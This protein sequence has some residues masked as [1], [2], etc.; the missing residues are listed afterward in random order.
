MT[1]DT[2][3]IPD[4][5]TPAPQPARPSPSTRPGAA[6]QPAGQEDPPV[7]TTK[8]PEGTAAGQQVGAGYRMFEL[9]GSGGMGAVYRGETK[10]GDPVA[11]KLLRPELASDTDMVRR[12]LQ[13]RAILTGLSH[14]NIVKIR[15]LVAEGGTIAIVMDLVQGPDLRRELTARKTLPPAQAAALMA[16]VLRG[17]AAVHAAGVVHRDIKPENVLLDQSAGAG[18]SVPKLTDFG[19]ARIA[20]TSDTLRQTTLIGTPLYMAP[21]LVDEKQPTVASDL[22]AAGI[23]LYEL[24]AG[25]TPFG[26]GT[27]MATLNKHVHES[28]GRPPG[29]PQALWDILTPMLAKDPAARPASAGVVAHALD[30]AAEKLAGLPALTPL[31]VPPPADPDGATARAPVVPTVPD[32]PVADVPARFTRRTL[33]IAGVLAVLLLA[34]GGTAAALYMKNSATGTPVAGPTTPVTTSSSAPTSSTTST[35]TT[36]TTS[37]TSSTS[38]T[39]AT[40]ST[41]SLTAGAAMPDLK[42]MKV[43]LALSTIART[44]VSYEIKEVPNT[45]VPDGTVLDQSPAAGQPL[46]PPI[47]ITVARTPTLVYLAD[48]KY[49]SER[50]VNSDS[51]VSVNGNTYIHGL[52]LGSVACGGGTASVEYDLSRRYTKL[53][54]VIGQTDRSASGVTTRTEISLDGKPVFSKQFG[55]GQPQQLDLD[56]TGALRL[57]IV[58]TNVGASN[59]CAR[60]SVAV[61]F[62]DPQLNGLPQPSAT[63]S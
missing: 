42:N 51:N 63:T 24:I 26:G 41:T 25:I 29:M 55:L 9:L 14:P 10:S 28:P 53:S 38:S 35:S 27:F 23:V 1:D 16:S 62:G 8:A 34:G 20:N 54:S 32:R 21:E 7:S 19:V 17:L 40:T 39:G 52:T 59:T 15:D 3:P 36:S 12:F 11:I 30:D 58:V 13:E 31:T 50:G 56:I 47:T 61:G 18:S 46:V 60:E 22:Y 44:G 43:Q 5:P 57:Q 4:E 2:T 37:T 49:V 33:I 6:E 48:L 45:T